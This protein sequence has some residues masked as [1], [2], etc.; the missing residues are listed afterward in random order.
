M[1]TS[2]K[3]RPSVYPTHPDHIRQLRSVDLFKAAEARDNHQV[4][5]EPK[6]KWRAAMRKWRAAMRRR[7]IVTSFDPTFEF[8]AGLNKRALRRLEDHFKIVALEAGES[9]GRQGEVVDEFVLILVGQVGVTIDG[10]AVAVLGAG[11]HFGER[12]LLSASTDPV[13]RAS[14]TAL[15][16][17]T[18]GTAP[19]DVFADVVEK[20]PTV[21]EQV[22]EV[23]MVREA[24]LTGR[25]H[26][27]ADAYPVDHHQRA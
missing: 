15:S 13:L 9:L 22:R 2:E 27:A 25:T 24:Y 3:R 8:C 11:N 26:A 20:F 23:A 12:A 10:N 16:P 5:R 1:G 17:V 6:R 4:P 18:M 19:Q 14:F 21:A 7:R